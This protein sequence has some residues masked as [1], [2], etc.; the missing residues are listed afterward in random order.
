MIDLAADLYTAEERI[1]VLEGKSEEVSRRQ[2]GETLPIVPFDKRKCRR[3]VKIY[4]G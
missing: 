3:D 4:G 2:Q 1:S